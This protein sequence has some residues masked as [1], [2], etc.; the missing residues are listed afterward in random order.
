MTEV[1]EALS[2]PILLSLPPEC[3]KEVQT[4]GTKCDQRPSAVV[5]AMVLHSTV[6]PSLPP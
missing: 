1:E 2:L 6:R 5:L 4:G 3:E